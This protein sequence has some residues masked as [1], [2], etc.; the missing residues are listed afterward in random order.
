VDFFVR[1]L[2]F[3]RGLSLLFKIGLI[4]LACSFGFGV[5]RLKSE[6]IVA[7]GWLEKAWVYFFLN[8]LCRIS[9][10]FE[11]LPLIEELEIGSLLGG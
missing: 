2:L 9:A 11:L 7:L 8:F 1:F 4:E 6:L 5:N 10:H 3:F